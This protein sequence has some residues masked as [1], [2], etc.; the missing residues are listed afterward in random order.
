MSNVQTEQSE[1]YR[2]NTRVPLHKSWLS[3]YMSSEVIDMLFAHQG[4]VMDPFSKAMTTALASIRTGRKC[5]SIEK[6]KDCFDKV[7]G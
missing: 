2:K 3:M 1:L 7:L 4:Y 5:L 6:Y